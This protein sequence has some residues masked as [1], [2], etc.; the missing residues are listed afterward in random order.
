MKT[1]SVMRP[2]ESQRKVLNLERPVLGA[3]KVEDAIDSPLRGID[4][5]RGAMCAT[6]VR[7]HIDKSIASHNALGLD[8][9]GEFLLHAVIVFIADRL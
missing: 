9:P 5:M 2:R 7:N 8:E 4:V 3:S 6:G 1:K